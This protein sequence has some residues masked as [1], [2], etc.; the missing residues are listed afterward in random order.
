MPAGAEHGLES[1]IRDMTT[2]MTLQKVMGFGLA[3]AGLLG[4]VYLLP[5]EYRAQFV[6]ALPYLVL[7]ACPLM[8]LFMHRGHGGGA[9]DSHGRH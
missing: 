8:H 9:G 6:D 3:L 5:A 4:V 7:L 1:E 2:T